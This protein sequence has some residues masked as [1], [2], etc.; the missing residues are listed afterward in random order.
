ME[1]CI[2][3]LKKVYEHSLLIY[4]ATGNTLLRDRRFE[5]VCNIEEAFLYDFLAYSQASDSDFLKC[6]EGVFV[7]GSC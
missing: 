4:F 1:S 3:L 7:T 2:I 5:T 6:P